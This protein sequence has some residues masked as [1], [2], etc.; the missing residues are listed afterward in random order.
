MEIVLDNHGTQHIIRL[1]G[2]HKEGL[3]EYEPHKSFNLTEGENPEI[4][5]CKL[6]DMKKIYI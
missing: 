4:K 1:S 2:S 6:M 3:L 5:F